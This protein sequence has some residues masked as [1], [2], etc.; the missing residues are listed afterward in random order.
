MMCTNLRITAPI[1][2]PFGLPRAA[3]RAANVWNTSL[4]R[5]AVIAGQYSAARTRAAFLSEPSHRIQFVYVPK[6]TSWL[7]QIEIWFSIV[8]ATGAQARQLQFSRGVARAHSRV[9]CLR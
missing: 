3:S 7:N 5:I 6:Y 1:I 4:H 9:Y 2:T 8:G